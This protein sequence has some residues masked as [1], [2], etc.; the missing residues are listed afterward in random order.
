MKCLRHSRFGPQLS[1]LLSLNFQRRMVSYQAYCLGGHFGLCLDSSPCNEVKWLVPGGLGESFPMTQGSLFLTPKGTLVK[2]DKKAR[3]RGR[4]SYRN[5]PGTQ[6]TSE[7][8]GGQEG[9]GDWCV[10][11]WRTVVQIHIKALKA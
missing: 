7:G 4:H 8:R 3:C 10:G 9:A 11:A 1:A 2:E 5:V 6:S